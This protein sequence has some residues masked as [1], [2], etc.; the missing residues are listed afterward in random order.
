[1]IRRTYTVTEVA[2]IL[3]ISRTSA[4]EAVHRGE[5]PSVTI[6]RR[7]LIA[8]SVLERFLDPESGEEPLAAS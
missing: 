8:H 6:G 4:Y 5:I 1:M 2:K 7:I 3:G